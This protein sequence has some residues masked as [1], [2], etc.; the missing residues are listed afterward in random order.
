MKSV[1]GEDVSFWKLKNLERV[2]SGKG[3]GS[4]YQVNIQPFQTI[5]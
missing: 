2:I 1:T 4:L 3:V 5:M